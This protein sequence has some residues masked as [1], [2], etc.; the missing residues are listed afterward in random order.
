MKNIIAYY[1]NL[2][3]YD[4]HQIQGIY[5]FSVGNDNYALEPCNIL[6][7]DRIYKI[8]KILLQNNIYV[9]QIIP[10]ISNNIYMTYNN[11]NYILLKIGNITCKRID[12]ND[13]IKFNRS[14][15]IIN[16]NSENIPST[17]WGVL[18][19]KKIDYFEY[20]INQFGKKHPEIRESISYYIG[21]VETGIS[22]YNNTIQNFKSKKSISH[23]RINKNSTLY[24]LYNP[25]NLIV[26]YKVRDA[27]EYFKNLFL[28]KKNIFDDIV[29]YFY[30]E[31]LSL[32]DCYIF[33]IRMFYPSFYFDT[34]ES[35]INNKIEEDKIQLIIENTDLYEKILRDVYLYLSNF[36]QMPDIEW[37]KKV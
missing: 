33:F 2:Y 36:I 8:Y 11:V 22:L 15:S 23:K 3:S 29:K 17:D 6:E 30:E 20:Q 5:K 32:N 19:S 28:N 27:T 12:L 24:D 4:I 31:Q 21:M 26:D 10:T 13:I 35:I 14:V 18:W 37:L 7:L 34:Y 9:H 25:L 1:Y 16:I